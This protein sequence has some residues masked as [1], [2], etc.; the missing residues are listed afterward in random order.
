MLESPLKMAALS[1][2]VRLFDDRAVALQKRHS[3]DIVLY[4]VLAGQT[5]RVAWCASYCSFSLHGSYWLSIGLWSMTSGSPLNIFTHLTPKTV[6]IGHASAHY[7]SSH[8]N[9]S[10]AAYWTQELMAHTP[11]AITSLPAADSIVSPLHFFIS[12]ANH[13]SS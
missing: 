8:L 12:L 7:S 9:P 6:F 3:S 10:P 5:L 1:A 13:L 11:I 4:S 2:T